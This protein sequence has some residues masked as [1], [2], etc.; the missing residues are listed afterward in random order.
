MARLTYKMIR[1][2]GSGRY[3]LMISA[4]VKEL[5][6]Y[7]KIDSPF[8]F[9]DELQR[10]IDNTPKKTAFHFWNAYKLKLEGRIVQIWRHFADLHQ[11]AVLVYEIKEE[12]DNG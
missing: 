9:I 10:Y 1:S 12:A 8:V 6:D 2:G 5:I 11:E 4:K 7:Y 3:D